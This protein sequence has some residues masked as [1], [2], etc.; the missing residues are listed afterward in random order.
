MDFRRA[1]ESR[2]TART[3][4]IISLAQ[5]LHCP[6]GGAS[7]PEQLGCWLVGWSRRDHQQ[8]T[9]F[10]SRKLLSQV[11]ITL[12]ITVLIKQKNL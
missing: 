9:V 12:E 3:G 5:F 4:E 7:R 8:G 1:N 6:P 11:F 10:K 2:R